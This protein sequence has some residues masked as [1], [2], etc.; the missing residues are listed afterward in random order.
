M[1]PFYTL[2]LLKF[3]L[4]S[5]KLVEKDI[6]DCT[7]YNYFDYIIQNAIYILNCI[8]CNLNLEN[9][10]QYKLNFRLYN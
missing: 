10:S 5:L 6:L 2:L 7:I 1:F 8:I 4:Y 3:Q 9:N